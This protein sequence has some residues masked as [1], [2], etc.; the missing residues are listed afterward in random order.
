MPCIIGYNATIFNTILILFSVYIFCQTKIAATHCDVAGCGLRPLPYALFCN[1]LTLDVPDKSKR[2]YGY[3]FS[4]SDHKE[5]CDI[6]NNIRG[7]A[8]VTHYEHPLYDELYKNWYKYEFQNFKV[9]YGLTRQNPNE[10]KR[11]KV[12]EIAYCSFIPEWALV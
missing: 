6:L 8:V 11:P 7:M 2:Y 3:G 4:E 10:K 5:L 1:K 12:K 9:S